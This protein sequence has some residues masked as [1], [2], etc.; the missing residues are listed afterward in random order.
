MHAVCEAYGYDSYPLLAY[1]V[2]RHCGVAPHFCGTIARLIR[3]LG[4]IFSQNGER[5]CI[6]VCI[7]DLAGRVLLHMVFVLE[8]NA[9]IEEQTKTSAH[10]MTAGFLHDEAALWDGLQ[11]ICCQQ[12]PGHHL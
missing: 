6:P 4:W 5:Q 12:W 1:P 2:K 3:Y 10:R 9:P 7:E 8:G 11:F